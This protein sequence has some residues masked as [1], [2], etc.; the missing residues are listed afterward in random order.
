MP[1]GAA[2][3]QSVLAT[4]STF[5]CTTAA[6]AL[7]L[8]RPACAPHWVFTIAG[9]R[10]PFTQSCW[11]R[12]RPRPADPATST[13]PT[14]RP[15]APR[16]ALNPCACS[17]PE[18]C[19]LAA[20]SDSRRRGLSSASQRV[21]RRRWQLSCCSAFQCGRA[22]PPPSSPH[23][24][25]PSEHSGSSSAAITMPMVPASAPPT[26]SHRNWPP[27]CRLM[28]AS[29][30]TLIP[31]G[32]IFC[33][34]QNLYLDRFQQLLIKKM[35][36]EPPL[37]RAR[38]LGK[39][40]SVVFRQLHAAGN[41]EA[42]T[43]LS[44]RQLR[45]AAL[46]RPS[47]VAEV[48]AQLVAAGRVTRSSDGYRFNR[49]A[50]AILWFDPRREHSFVPTAVLTAVAR[51]ACQGWPR[52]RG[53]PFGLG[54]DRREHGG[55]LDWSW[56]GGCG[57]LDGDAADGGGLSELATVSRFPTS[58]GLKGSGNGKHT[59][60]VSSATDSAPN[61]RSPHCSISDISSSGCGVA[62]CAARV[63]GRAFMDASPRRDACADREG[64]RPQSRASHR[65]ERGYVLPPRSEAG[66]PWWHPDARAQRQ[67]LVT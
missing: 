33:G 50:R 26:N 35:L 12:S 48:L 62:S 65:A 9:H 53:H 6:S 22:S 32:M 28:S 59:R 4:R 52:L 18:R 17:A 7:R 60:S 43:P 10:P 14:S 36:S 56:A 5:G 11:L 49:C 29:P 47:H 3:N 54:L 31:T 38:R 37:A 61:P 30:T 58:I 46:I 13:R 24:S 45:D 64:Q 51:R 42:K 1:Y 19:R 39:F 67:E 55:R 63:V 16:R 41:T 8:F 21:S 20:P 44:Q 66:P 23:S 25:P 2:A 57:H 27:L 34:K 15:Q 40:K